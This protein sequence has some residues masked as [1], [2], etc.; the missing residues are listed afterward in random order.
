MNVCLVSPPILDGTEII[1]SD[2][3]FERILA[4]KT[5][6]GVLTLAAILDR[7]GVSYEL[8]HLSRH[9]YEGGLPGGSSELA[10]LAA[11]RIA[12]G[13]FDV[14]G[15]STVCSSYP[16]TLRFATEIKRRRPGCT[17]ILGGP[18]ATVTDVVTMRSFESI[19]IVVRGEADEILP[20][21]LECLSRRRSLALLQGVTYREGDRIVRNDNAPPVADLDSLPMPAFHLLRGCRGSSVLSLEIGRGCPFACTFCSTNDFFRRNFRLK[22]DTTMIAQMTELHSRY[23]VAKFDLTHDLYTVD[24]RRVISFCRALLES[25]SKLKWTCSARTDCVDE[26]LLDWMK[27]AGC[28]GVFFGI[29]TGSARM[30]R[31]IDK[32]LDLNRVRDAIHWCGE[33]GIGVKAATIIGFPEEEEED[34]NA[35][36]ELLFEAAARKHVCPQ[37]TYL[38]PLVGT[39]VYARYHDQLELGWLIADAALQGY[40]QSPA[41]VSLITSYPEVF[42]NFYAA[43]TRLPR[44]FLQETVLL[45]TW[46]FLRCRWLVVALARSLGGPLP[47]CRRW[48][49]FRRP[50]GSLDQLV[51]YYASK[52][53]HRDFIRFAADAP[54]AGIE[55]K[56]LALV[57][58]RLTDLDGLA[59]DDKEFRGPVSV[60]GF[61]VISASASIFTVPVAPNEVIG[62]LASDKPFAES[63]R[64]PVTVAWIRNSAGARLL[65]LPP[66]VVRLLSLCDGTRQA[67]E[68]A[69]CMGAQFG[70]PV[71]NYDGTVGWLTAMERLREDGLL[72]SRSAALP[73]CKVDAGA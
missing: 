18:Q 28:V 5:G 51:K 31:I 16:L 10:A 57:D 72:I 38:E 33:R 49:A 20:R 50:A 54:E 66:S 26:E 44:Q 39:P 73:V 58:E 21:V 71:A 3:D 19:D 29:E 47:F 53:F 37:I 23:G 12:A 45:L 42:S 27:R 4:E 67:F 48:I 64:K 41:D 52:E 34:V 9:C 69:S 7:Q 55:A 59:V 30:Q 13:A 1:R 65:S 36:L 24:R 70:S 11:D 35:T 32:R 43:P 68:V 46:C 8:Q 22:S 17:V 40:D 60:D 25:G 61:P 2:A 56:V 63:G 62:A 15:I 6:L 14:I